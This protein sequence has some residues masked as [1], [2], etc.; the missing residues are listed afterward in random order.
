[1]KNAIQI[2]IFCEFH[3]IDIQ[4]V[5][6]IIDN[7]F[8]EVVKQEEVVFI[9]SSAIENLER[10]IRLSHDLGVNMAGLEVINNMR[11]KMLELREKLDNF[12]LIKQQYVDSIV[13][14]AEDDVL[15][16]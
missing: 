9:P 8:I 5:Y 6:S 13:M 11:L 4:L 10:C 12:E 3:K 15:D 2:E 16:I 1:M 14:D 7:G